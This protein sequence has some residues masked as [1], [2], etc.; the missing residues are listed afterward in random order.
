MSGIAP[1][2]RAAITDLEA[3]DLHRVHVGE[4]T[5]AGARR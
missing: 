4:L 1:A 2:L 5:T 3:A